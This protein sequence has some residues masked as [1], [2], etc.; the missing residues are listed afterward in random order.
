MTNGY[1]KEAA[2]GDVAPFVRLLNDADLLSFCVAF[3]MVTVV[4]PWVVILLWWKPHLQK[5]VLFNI[6]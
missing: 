4:C 3:V 6:P 1:R 5:A 2:H